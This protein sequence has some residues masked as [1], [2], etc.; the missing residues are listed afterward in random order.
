M[1]DSLVYQKSKPKLSGSFCK[2]CST[3][4]MGNCSSQAGGGKI[5]GSLRWTRK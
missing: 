3:V 4:P 5:K 2:T 1:K